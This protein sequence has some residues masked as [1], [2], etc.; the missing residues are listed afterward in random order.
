[1]FQV[2]YFHE[3]DEH[4]QTHQY[5][6]DLGTVLAW[7]IVLNYQNNEPLLPLQIMNNIEFISIL[8]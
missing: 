5:W 1:M 6:M 4:T 8:R 3:E 7:T 2:R